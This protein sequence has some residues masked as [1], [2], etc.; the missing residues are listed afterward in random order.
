MGSAYR[1]PVV[2]HDDDRLAVVGLPFVSLFGKELTEKAQCTS[3][4]EF[5]RLLVELRPIA[6]RGLA[7]G[8]LESRVITRQDWASGP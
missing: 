8:A 3:S 6:N 1:H 5:R 2:L 7:N 4:S